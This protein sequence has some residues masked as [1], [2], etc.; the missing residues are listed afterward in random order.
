MEI[1][2]TASPGSSV[3]VALLARAWIEMPERLIKAPKKEVALLARAWI[4]IPSRKRRYYA[5]LVALLARAWIE[6]TRQQVQESQQRGRSPC[7]SVD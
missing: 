3:G 6:I 5:Y 7:E 2:F 4:E 1:T